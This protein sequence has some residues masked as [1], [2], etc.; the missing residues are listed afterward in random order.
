MDS[1][2]SPIF[3]AYRAGAQAGVEEIKKQC[4]SPRAVA[5]QVISNAAGA[6][7]FIIACIGAAGILPGSTMGWAAVG[8][9]GGMLAFNLA[10]GNL[11]NRKTQVITIALLA[12]SYITVG[13]LGAAGILS[14][15][16]VGWGVI[17]SALAVGP[18]MCYVGCCKGIGSLGS[19]VSPSRP[20]R[21]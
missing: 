8:L 11:K 5:A 13:G 9:G 3:S 6:A 15:T 19:Q 17:G 12:I 7:L 21:F 20:A 16:Q 14:G 18:I 10:A 2:A 4:N 1:S